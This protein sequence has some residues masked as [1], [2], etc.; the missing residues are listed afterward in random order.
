MNEQNPFRINQ[1]MSTK[2]PIGGYRP[3]H[4]CYWPLLLTCPGMTSVRVPDGS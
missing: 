1:D 4:Y 2:P 3:L